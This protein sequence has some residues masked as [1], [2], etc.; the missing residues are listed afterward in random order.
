[1]EKLFC[2]PHAGASAT[3]YLK[4]Q[5][6]FNN[7]KIIPVEVSGRGTRF[8]DKREAT[9]SSESV[10]LCQ[11]IEKNIEPDDTFSVFGHSMGCFMAFEVICRLIEKPYYKNRLKNVFLSGNKAPH[12]ND[13][14]EHCS[15]VHLLSNE[16]FKNE[17]LKEGATSPEIF[18]N[19]MLFEV[20]EP[21]LREDYRITETYSFSE[22][23]IP[24]LDCGMYIMN[25]YDD[26]L[27]EYEIQQW[28][29]YCADRN[30]FDIK[31]FEGGHFYMNEHLE[32]VADY[33]SEK[34]LNI[35]VNV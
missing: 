21:I 29:R 12:L 19:K 27:E 1:M 35:G 32:E 5:K 33:I 20:F 2:I 30:K 7:I 26:N 13:K 24:K 25:G 8:S 10:A 23:D 3:V 18:E 4:W 16:D 11:M 14:K 34:L 15:N 22:A 9:L 6:Y 28:E 31:Y 17:I